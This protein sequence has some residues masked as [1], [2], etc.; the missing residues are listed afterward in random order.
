MERAQGRWRQS[1]SLL[2]P[3]ARASAG[4]GLDVLHPDTPSAPG[5]GFV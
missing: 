2:L 3:N 1:L 5:G 4:L